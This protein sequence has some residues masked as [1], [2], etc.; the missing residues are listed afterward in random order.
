MKS[1]EILE[2]IAK[3]VNASEPIKNEIKGS[4]KILQFD[5]RADKY[6]LHVSESGEI[7]LST[8]E[9]PTPNVTIFVTDE[10]MQDIL[11]SKLD[12]TKAFLEGK[13]KFKGDLFL[14]QKLI[15]IVKKVS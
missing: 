7:S 11:L 2:T 15:N 10:I 3:K 9:H 1:Y 12:E 6:F 13:I 8:G 5:M 4:S 14:T